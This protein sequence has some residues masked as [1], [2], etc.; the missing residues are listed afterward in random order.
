MNQTRRS[1]HYY[2]RNYIQKVAEEYPHEKYLAGLKRLE[3]MPHHD[4]PIDKDRIFQRMMFNR[5]AVEAAMK[6]VLRRSGG[7][8][9]YELAEM[10]YWKKT[11]TVVEAALELDMLPE[12]AQRLFREFRIILCDELGLILP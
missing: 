8:R 12:D 2:C 3:E 11:H 5:L 1:W 4:P 9:F 6:R 7:E 10:V